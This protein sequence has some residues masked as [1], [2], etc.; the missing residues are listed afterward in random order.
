[1]FTKALWAVD[2][3]QQAL[4][5]LRFA[6]G[7]GVLDEAEIHPRAAFDSGAAT[8]HG[9]RNLS[10]EI[11]D[12]L[13]DSVRDRCLTP[14]EALIKELGLRLGAS[15][16]QEGRA[17]DVIVEE[18]ERIEADLILIGRRGL[19]AIK[20]FLTGSVSQRV[21]L[22]ASCPVL[23]VPETLPEVAE[24]PPRLIL[25]TDL[26]NSAR[27][28]VDF[29]AGLAARIG[30]EVMLIHGFLPYDVFPT[31][32]PDSPV[33]AKEFEWLRGHVD[34]GLHELVDALADKNV[35]AHPQIYPQGSVNAVLNAAE[36]HKATLIVIASH[37]RSGWNKFWL[38]STADKIIKRAQHPV[39]LVPVGESESAE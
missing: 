5:A 19:G 34:K 22:G 18:A 14:A 12:E 28:G 20:R 26:S 16:M 33:I 31:G 2:G 9:L 37:G 24:G 30:A 25:P 13:H 11:M 4:N 17:A 35:R 8:L 23:I 38:G 27:R 7:L 32:Y 36:E 1:M 39:L 6:R 3:S 21:A 29:G 10:R 15:K